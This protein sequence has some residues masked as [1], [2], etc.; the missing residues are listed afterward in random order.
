MSLYKNGEEIHIQECM[1]HVPLV[2]LNCG[3]WGV[4]TCA[5]HPGDICIGHGGTHHRWDIHT[6]YIHTYAAVTSRSAGDHVPFSF[7]ELSYSRKPF[8]SEHNNE[9][10]R[11]SRHEQE[12][13][14][15]TYAYDLKCFV[16]YVTMW[17]HGIIS[18]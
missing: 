8:D 6:S 3:T 4:F 13:T 17:P 14:F 18:Y 5:N 15:F 10:K 2:S 9:S 1:T 16:L 7:L 12:L 11:S